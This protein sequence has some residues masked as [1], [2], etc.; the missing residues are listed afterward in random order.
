MSKTAIME[1]CTFECFVLVV[2]D[3]PLPLWAVS[4]IFLSTRL[5]TDFL[6]IYCW[7]D[8]MLHIILLF[9]FTA[10]NYTFFNKNA[11][12]YHMKNEI[13]YK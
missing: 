2:L 12:S 3:L 13:L 10:W 1:N 6:E 11:D 9:T 4:H 5:Q 8:R 7:T